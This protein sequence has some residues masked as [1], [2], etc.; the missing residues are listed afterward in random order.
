MTASEL[1]TSPDR[2]DPPSPAIEVGLDMARR[3]SP[4]LPV[5]MILGAVFGGFNGA[6][7]VAFGM[8]LVLFNFLLAAFL[9]GKAAKISFT[10]VAS[11]ALGG[12]VLRLGIIFLAFM[13]VKDM[14]WIAPMA[15][16]V[17]IVV[18][19]LGLLIWE[20]RYVSASLAYPGL[21]PRSS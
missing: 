1:N 15:L 13:V 10:L 19:H 2:F 3:G 18:T 21:K 6:M 7:S 8:V 12:Y 5:G 4:F 20:L 17:T 16:G 14:S 9:L 11:A